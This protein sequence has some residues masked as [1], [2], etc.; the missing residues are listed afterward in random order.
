ML[1]RTRLP[2]SPL[3]ASA[4]SR[5]FLPLGIAPCKWSTD[6]DTY[7]PIKG[8]PTN[9]NQTRETGIHRAEASLSWSSA[10][11]RQGFSGC[12][13]SDSWL[14]ILPQIPLTPFKPLLRYAFLATKAKLFLSAWCYFI[15]ILLHTWNQLIL[16]IFLQQFSQRRFSIA[17]IRSW[18]W[19][20]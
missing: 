5:Q 19:F 13:W 1:A 12:C 3:K 9:G 10:R 17:P 18:L 8:G 14:R 6:W 2:K 20:C 11:P 7:I 15:D 4:L 16:L